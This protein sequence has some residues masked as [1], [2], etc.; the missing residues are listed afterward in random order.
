MSNS[1]FSTNIELHEHSVFVYLL[2]RTRQTIYSCL[3]RK[4]IWELETACLRRKCSGIQVKNNKL[5]KKTVTRAQNQVYE[6]DRSWN[7]TLS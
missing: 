2:A 1:L 3:E 7:I 5:A 6:S 4:R